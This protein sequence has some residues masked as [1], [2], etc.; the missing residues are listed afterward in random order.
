MKPKK[1]WAN[2]SVTDLARTTRFYQ[3][4]GFK[5]FCDSE[6]LTSFCFGDEDFI[7]HFFKKERF[8]IDINGMTTGSSPGSEIIF[9]LMAESREEVD[10]CV[11]EVEKAGGSVFS[12]PR[13]F[14]QGYTVGFSDPDGH[15]F[16]LLYWPS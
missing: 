2:L 8:D 15:K 13:E 1:I 11:E 10:Q 12:S 9:S 5:P 7:I 14:G 3:A 4:L 16:N 6:E